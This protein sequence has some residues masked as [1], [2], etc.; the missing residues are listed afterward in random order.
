MWS[1]LSLADNLLRM[2]A[3]T[4]IPLCAMAMALPAFCAELAGGTTGLQTN[5]VLSDYSALARSSELLRRFLSPLNALRVSQAATR[6]AQPLREAPLDLANETFVVY[7]PARAPPE[8]YALLVFVPPWETATLPA[9]WTA[10]LDR[11][12][13]IYASAAKSGNT[14]DVLDRREPLALLAALNMLQRFPVNPKRVYIGGLSGGARVALRIALAYPDVFH[15]A[16]L[17]AGSDPIGTAEIPL[18]PAEL[19]RKFQESTRV[20]YLTGARDN[21]HLDADLA[22]RQSLN[23]WCAFNLSTETV[24][25]REHEILNA[26]ALSRGLDALLTQSAPDARKISACRDRIDTALNQELKRVEEL[27]AAGKVAA[28]QRLLN[29]I[30]A[31]YGGLAGSR[32]V[33]LAG[34]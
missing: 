16:L 22:S 10:A 20:V 11:N 2:I 33:A 26:A 27:L 9:H 25:W 5:V 14:A 3:R 12:A 7:V 23:D 17:N 31:H 8:G 13:M 30:D 15:G 19:L 29:K 21:F 34:Q 6:S 18:P 28:A 4:L 32:S 1:E 24:P